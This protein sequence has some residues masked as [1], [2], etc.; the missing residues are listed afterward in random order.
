MKTDAMLI[1]ERIAE[2]RK[3]LRLTQAQVGARMNPYR[4]HSAVSALELGKTRLSLPDLHDLAAILG[5]PVAYFMRN[6]ALFEHLAAIEHQA[7][8]DQQRFIHRCC[9]KL[10][11]GSIAIPANMVEYWERLAQTP[12]HQ[13]SD[14]EKQGC[15]DHV[16]RYWSLV[17]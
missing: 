4:S 9:V 14:R 13:L 3:D 7:W 6:D 12:Y 11:N 10:V 2:A 17:S 1:G 15:R 16:M 5:K 8:S